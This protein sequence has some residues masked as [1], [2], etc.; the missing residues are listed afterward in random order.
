M[1]INEDSFNL[2]INFINNLNGKKNDG[3][4][5]QQIFSRPLFIFPNFIQFI[6][7]VFYPLL[8]PFYASQIIFESDK[9]IKKLKNDII[10]S[11]LTN[12]LLCPFC[13]HLFLK[14]FRNDKNNLENLIFKCFFEPL[15]QFPSLYQIIDP[16]VTDSISENDKIIHILKK[17]IDVE[18]IESII[19]ILLDDKNFQ[20]KKFPFSNDGLIIQGCKIINNI[21]D[22]AI[23]HF[24]QI[25]L[26]DGIEKISII[27][28]IKNHNLEKYELMQ[29][30]FA[31]EF[32]NISFNNNDN[33]NNHFNKIVNDIFNN[34]NIDDEL[35]DTTI[36]LN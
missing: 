1:F 22:I 31:E 7:K 36:L 14:K 4:I 5:L 30:K 15:I 27:E 34:D 9:I 11:V 3:F 23:D 29:F 18:L 2:Y 33:K 12:I 10:N 20:M 32:Y 16:W 26:N 21:D 6:K 35:D 17:T 13:I 25:L 28:D 19:Q 8:K 24:S